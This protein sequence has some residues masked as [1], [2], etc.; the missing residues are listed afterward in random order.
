MSYDEI[1]DYVYNHRISSYSII[2]RLFYELYLIDKKEGDRERSHEIAD[3]LLILAL[4]TVKA[5]FSISFEMVE[6]IIEQY[7]S[8]GKWYA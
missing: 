8:I 5:D 2:K 1:S 4:R 7:N 3:E 6:Y